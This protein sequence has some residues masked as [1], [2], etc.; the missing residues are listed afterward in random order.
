MRFRTHTILAL[1]ALAASL[2]A[3]CRPCAALE[4]DWERRIA[5]EFSEVGTGATPDSGIT[6]HLR[7]VLSREALSAAVAP[8]ANVD[9]FET[10]VRSAVHRPGGAA[11]V[12]IEGEMSARVADIALVEPD[13]QGRDALVTLTAVVA[14][15]LDALDRR[16]AMASSVATITV[17][18]PLRFVLVE[19]RPAIVVDLGVAAVERLDFEAGSMPPGFADVPPAVVAEVAGRMAESLLRTA[20]G[21][22]TALAWPA[23]DSPWSEIPLVPSSFAVDRVAGTLTLGVVTSLR[24]AGRLAPSPPPPD[25]GYAL[26]VH[27]DLWRAAAVQLQAVGRMPRRFDAD[28]RSSVDGGFRAAIDRAVIDQTGVSCE[29]TV[30]CFAES[31]QRVEVRSDGVLAAEDGEIAVALAA[32]PNRSAA[33]VSAASDALFGLAAQLLESLLSPAPLALG[34]G[35]ELELEVEGVMPRRGGIRVHGPVRTR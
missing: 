34:D 24:P 17:R 32:E 5:R 14:I 35:A 26:D 13:P 16:P 11:E 10:V 2:G 6:D 25:G 1:L 4:E 7:L 12:V 8:L 19:R 29:L 27:P 18:A 28:G 15:E 30:W 3:A 9:L 33:E 22:V 23:I 20:R 31:C 21:P